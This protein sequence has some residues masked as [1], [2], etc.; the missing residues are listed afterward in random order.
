[1]RGSACSR[2]RARAPGPGGPNGLGFR[3][4]HLVGLAA[5]RAAHPRNRRVQPGLELKEVQVS[6]GATYPLMHWLA[7]RP[8]CR[9]RHA[10]ARVHHLEVDAPLDR[11]QFDFV[12]LPRIG[13]PQ[14]RREQS[15]DFQF[16]HFASHRYNPRSVPPAPCR[17]AGVKSS[18]MQNDEEP[19]YP[20]SRKSYRSAKFPN[21]KFRYQI[22][23]YQRKS[24]SNH[25]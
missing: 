22:S 4:R 7:R 23:F 13:Q 24:R 9:A 5:R 21:P 10:S 17:A 3:Y 1:M 19:K 2:G 8:A 11:I 16:R 15:F 14:R 20:A 18:S 6:S 12:H 25:Q